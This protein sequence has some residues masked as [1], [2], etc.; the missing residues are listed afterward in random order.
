MIGSVDNVRFYNRAINK[1]E[2]RKVF[3]TEK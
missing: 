3:D 2:V 1:Y